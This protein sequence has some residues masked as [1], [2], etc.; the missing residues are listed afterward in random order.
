MKTP[1]QSFSSGNFHRRTDNR[2]AQCFEDNYV[3]CGLRMTHIMSSFILQPLHYISRP[4]RLHCSNNT[5]LA[6][7]AHCDSKIGRLFTCNQGHTCKQNARRPDVFTVIAAV[8]ISIN[9]SQK[10]VILK[11]VMVHRKLR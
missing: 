4:I 8:I 6:K 2:P 10:T 11:H 1:R 5:V 7:A 3:G 9:P